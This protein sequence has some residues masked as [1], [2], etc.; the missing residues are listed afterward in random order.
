MPINLE[1]MSWTLLLKKFPK[2]Q[3]TATIKNVK[4]RAWV[5]CSPKR[6]NGSDIDSPKKPF[7]NN[8][9]WVDRYKI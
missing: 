7:F 4:V 1:Q 3:S 2:I 9:T 5:C 8:T 6:I